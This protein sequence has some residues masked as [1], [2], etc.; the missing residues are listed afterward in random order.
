MC[1]RVNYLF[2]PP[3]NLSLYA[4][5][6]FHH[7]PVVSVGHGTSSCRN[8]LYFSNLWG[9]DDYDDTLFWKVDIEI[10]IKYDLTFILPHMW[11]CTTET[12]FLFMEIL[13]VTFDLCKLHSNFSKESLDKVLITTCAM[14]PVWN[15]RECLNNCIIILYHLIK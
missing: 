14:K 7:D 6:Y 2:S 11:I 5:G 15:T 9:F 4:H 1:R 13:F 8:Y 12:R 10:I 3:V